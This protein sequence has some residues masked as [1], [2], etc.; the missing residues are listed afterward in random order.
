MQSYEFLLILAVILLSTKVFGLISERVHMPQVVGA[1]L[2]GVVL[3][4]SVLGLVEETDFLLKTSE[5]GVILLMFMAGLDTDLEE[6]KKTGLASFVIALIGVVVPLIAGT[7]LYLVFFP[8]MG[9]PLHMLKA[10]FIG[11]VLTA[12]SVSITVETLREMGRL[13]GKV[14]TAILGAA[15]IDDIMGIIVLTLVSAMTDPTVQPIAVLGRIVA[16]FILVVIVG[17]V[18]YRLFRAITNEWSN[19]RRIAIYALSFCLIL[20]FV[21]EHYFGIA[22]IT[23]AYFAGLIL[24]NL[25]EA[26]EYINKKVNILAYMFFSPVFFASMGIKTELDGMTGSLLIFSFA[27]LAIAIITKIV[28]CGLGAKLM[29]FNWSDSLSIG[30]GMVS[31][32]EVALIVAQKGAQV[33]LIDSSLFPPIV[34]V[35]IVTTLI[36]PILL[37]L[38]MKSPGEGTPPSIRHDFI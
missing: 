38:F 25:L 16:F 1:L 23:G 7:G 18:M 32:G 37:K 21:A 5:I 29:G 20:S 13:K 15:I 6:L 22:D 10:L 27:L 3:G 4:P 36:T 19:H 28:G 31:R 26:R 30:L 17:F 14:G 33:G 8:D 2:A 12:T 35:V 34:L 11:V 24:C 9:E